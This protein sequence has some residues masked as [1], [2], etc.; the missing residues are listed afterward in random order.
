MKNKYG[1]CFVKGVPATPKDTEQL[2]ERIAFIRVTHCELFCWLRIQGWPQMNLYRMIDA[3]SALA[4]SIDGGFWDFTADLAHGDT[5]YTNLALKAHTDNTYFV[6]RTHTAVA[7][8]V[9]F[10]G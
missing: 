9:I 2:I 8:L 5:A 4:R 1:F 7:L 10:S 6:S 3:R